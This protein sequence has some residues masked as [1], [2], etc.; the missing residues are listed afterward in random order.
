MNPKMA[1]SDPGPSPAASPMQAPPMAEA[2]PVDAGGPTV[3]VSSSPNGGYQTVTDQGDGQPQV[4]D[5]PDMD[6]V[7]AH[8]NQ[9]FGCGDDD[10]MEDDSQMPDVAKAPKALESTSILG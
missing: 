3:E 10:G 5:H 6:S 4:M 9:A 2:E 8:L 1:Q 7:A